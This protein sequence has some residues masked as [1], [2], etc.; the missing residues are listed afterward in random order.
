MGVDHLMYSVF[1]I[2]DMSLADDTAEQIR[3]LLRD[4]HD[5][6]DPA[7]DDFRVTTMAEMMA[8]LDVMTNAITFLLLAIVIISLIVGGVGVLNIMYVI[9]AQRTKEI[10]L[11]KAVGATNKDILAQFLSESVLI[12]FWGAIWGIVVGIFLAWV[13]ALIVRQYGLDWR[14][15]VPPQT[16]LVV[17]LFAFVFGIFFGFYPARKAANLDPVL[18]LNK[19]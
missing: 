9:V 4:N 7:K 2:K 3:Q 6:S 14:F 18:A 11:R 12:T 13:L 16:F 10:G 1:Q 5:I 15:G 19:E 17:F 8:M